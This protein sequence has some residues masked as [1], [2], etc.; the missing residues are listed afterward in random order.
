MRPR[1]WHKRRRWGRVTAAAALAATAGALVAGVAATGRGGHAP[2][3]RAESASLTPPDQGTITV[4]CPKH[5]RASGGGFDLGGGF[6]H[7]AGTGPYDGADQDKAPDDGW[8]FAAVVGAGPQVQATAHAVCI[9][10]AVRYRSR[11]RKILPPLPARP[12]RGGPPP[13]PKKLKCPGDT[14]VIGGGML[15]TTIPPGPDRIAIDSSFPFDGGDPGSKPDDGWAARFDN[16]TG[17]TQQDRYTV[18]AIC[19]A[20]RPTYRSKA[21]TIPSGQTAEAEAVCPSRTHLLGGGVE[22]ESANF[23]QALPSVG[24]PVDR[25]DAGTAPD[26]GFAVA[27]GDTGSGAPVTLTAHAICSG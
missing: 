13:P 6:G 3:Y 9:D 17:I 7:V 18:Y 26:D 24:H 27:A 14:H 19:R 5:T 25:D 12:T 4:G 21:T 8:Q 11:T 20:H 23:L 10:S 15:L 1:S 22:L 16:Q 2:R